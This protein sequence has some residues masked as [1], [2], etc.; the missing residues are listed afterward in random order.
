MQLWIKFLMDKDQIK[1]H[2]SKIVTDLIDGKITTHKGYG[3]ALSFFRQEFESRQFESGDI[4][5]NGWQYDHWM[6]F[7]KDGMKFGY[8]GSGYYGD[9]CI[10]KE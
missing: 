8:S 10:S 5:T 4:D 1:I 6:T 2:V 9:F 7:S 3:I